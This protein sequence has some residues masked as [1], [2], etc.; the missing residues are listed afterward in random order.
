MD[1]DIIKDINY[2]LTNYYEKIFTFDEHGYITFSSVYDQI[3]P[4]FYLVINQH[5]KFNMN[6]LTFTEFYNKHNII[7]NN[8]THL[9]LSDN[10]ADITQTDYDILFNCIQ[11]LPILQHL[12]I[13]INNQTN[14]NLT[15]SKLPTTLI[16]LFIICSNNNISCLDNLPPTLKVLSICA[17][18]ISLDNLPPTL[19][20]LKIKNYGDINTLNNLPPNLKILVIICKNFNVP[21]SNLPNTLQYIAINSTNN[22]D[23]DCIPSSLKYFICNLQIYNKYMNIY[24]NIKL[25]ELQKPELSICDAY[26]TLQS[27]Q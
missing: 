14:I 19:E 17:N 16:S 4:K 2:V 3:I 7:F 15:C 22:F 23:I 11:T 27:N 20:A 10:Y 12:K 13:F 24:T 9:S 21:I 1:F 8:I 6:I 26:Y 25:K 18:Y 5:D